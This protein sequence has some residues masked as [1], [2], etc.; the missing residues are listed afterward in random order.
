MRVAFA[1]AHLGVH[2]DVTTVGVAEAVPVQEAQ[3]TVLRVFGG[4]APVRRIEGVVDGEEHRCLVVGEGGDLDGGLEEPAG[5]TGVAAVL[6]PVHQ[7]QFDGTQVLTAARAV[8]AYLDVEDDRAFEGNGPAGRAGD[9][10][11]DRVFHRLARPH[12]AGRALVRGFLG[13]GVAAPA[14][15]D[16]ERADGGRDGEGEPH[17][18]GPDVTG[19]LGG[20][21]VPGFAVVALALVPGFAVR[22]LRGGQGDLVGPRGGGPRPQHADEIAVA[23]PG[24]RPRQRLGLT[25]PRPQQ[26]T[27]DIGD[28]S[29][30]HAVRVA[31][32]EGLRHFVDRMRDGGRVGLGRHVV[33][34]FGRWTVGPPVELGTYNNPSKIDR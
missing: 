29:V 30:P 10:D 8:V 4:M 34:P 20:Q 16:A 6:L 1:V 33:G 7:G 17:G 14:G 15:G 26:V 28:E 2:G 32:E 25:V 21:V 11:V 31:G 23:G 18:G 5:V 24:G 13:L 22:A 9:V 3:T 27:P 19:R 12:L